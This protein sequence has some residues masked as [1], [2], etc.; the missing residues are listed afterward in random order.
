MDPSEIRQ[1]DVVSAKVVGTVL[2]KED[3]YAVVRL[4]D[5]NDSMIL[6]QWGEPTD[7]HV[8][9]E[10]IDSVVSREETQ[11]EAYARI[12]SE[13]QTLVNA[14][15]AWAIENDML[16][17]KV[18]EL[19]RYV[20][21]LSRPSPETVKLTERIEKFLAENAELRNMNQ[22]LSDRITSLYRTVD[23][24]NHP[25]PNV[26]ELEH[27]LEKAL[28]ENRKI[29]EEHESDLERLARLEELSGMQAPQ[30][31]TLE[32]RLA[33]GKALR[34]NMT[35]TPEFM[36]SITVAERRRQAEDRLNRPVGFEPKIVSVEEISAAQALWNDPNVDPEDWGS[37]HGKVRHEGGLGDNP[38]VP[39]NY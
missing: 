8:P 22:E 36:D 6:N 2:Q 29:R 24:L 9:Y 39:T 11:E 17:K 12:R 30:P 26:T 18:F 13:N 3:S 38:F 4:R 23:A 21:D 16:A 34:R 14:N 1:Y 31:I 25:N 10:C 15:M 7:F 28:T 5:A 20:D 37:V 33:M 27:R 32:D 19:Q 35:Q